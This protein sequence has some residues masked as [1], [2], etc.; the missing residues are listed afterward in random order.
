MRNYAWKKLRKWKCFSTI[1]C[2]TIFSKALKAFPVPNSFLQFVWTLREWEFKN[3][4]FFYYRRK[5]LFNFDS[6][7]QHQLSNWWIKWGHVRKRGCFPKSEQAKLKCQWISISY[8]NQCPTFGTPFKNEFQV[9]MNVFKDQWQESHP[10]RTIQLLT[11][12]EISF[13][14]AEWVEVQCELMNF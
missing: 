9:Q 1:C 3:V 4:I 14:I 7:N 11:Q 2:W 10:I 13:I 5:N 12:I 6:E 8:Y